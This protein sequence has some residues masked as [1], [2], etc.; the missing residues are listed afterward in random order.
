MARGRKP[1][2]TALK[3][4]AGDGKRDSGG[5]LI[6]DDPNTTQGAPPMPPDVAA[7]PAVAEAWKEII[8]EVPEGVITHS[9]KIALSLLAKTV[10]DARADYKAIAHETVVV[11]NNV[12]QRTPYFEA[13]NKNRDS[14]W[15]MLSDFG[16]TP[17]SRAKFTIVKPAEKKDAGDFSDL[18]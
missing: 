10:V 2:P 17:A 4:L 6:A 14:V 3:K 13:W 8:S 15:K 12:P 16:M 9:D 11:V 7:D 5:R 1:I 18:D